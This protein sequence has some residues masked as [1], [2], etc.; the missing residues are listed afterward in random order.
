MK[1]IRINDETIV[2]FDN[3]N[4]MQNK[5]T[6]EEYTK[7]CNCKNEDEVFLLM[8]PN[9][10]E[11]L[12]ERKE[13]LSIYDAIAESNILTK[14]GDSIYWKEVCELS[15]PKELVEAVLQAEQTGDEDKLTSYKNFWTLMALNPDSRCRQN[16]FWFLNKWGMTISKYGLFV[17]YRNAD[18]LEE[19]DTIEGTK[20]Y[21]QD[22]VDFVKY[23]Y[24][25]IKRNRKSPKQYKVAFNNEGV[26]CPMLYKD[27]DGT[28]NYDSLYDLYNEFK[29]KN[30]DLKL[31]NHNDE[32]V[33]T[34]HY[35]HSF[36]IKIGELV[37]MDRSKCDSVQE[38]SCSKGLHVGGESWLNQGY[39]GD[40]GL[41]C[42]VN[43]KDVVAVPHADSYGKLRTCAYLPIGTVSFDSKGKVIPY[44]LEDGFESKYVTEVLYSG[45]KATEESATYSINIPEIP[46][47]NKTTITQAI[48]DIANQAIKD[49]V[50]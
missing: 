38:N 28:Y 35:T 45:D 31:I 1:I 32:N 20:L 23:H 5:L 43:P 40:A 30:F 19:G 22:E 25:R 34:D 15:M 36:R 27:I 47:L 12:T 3:G 41:I 6:E 50:Q 7:L 10:Q 18:F 29:E 46:E 14:V 13:V 24:E 39:F 42:L 37:T 8:C 49:K 9:Y 48:L 16:L 2:M 26:Y 21:T 11:V 17:G 44:N 33:Y 4:V